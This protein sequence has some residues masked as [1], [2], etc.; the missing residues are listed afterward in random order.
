MK[1]NLEQNF[2]DLQNQFDVEEPTVG[3]LNR[4]EAKLARASEEKQSSKFNSKNWKWF[5]VA[6]AVIVSIGLWFVKPSMS[7]QGMQLAEVS[8]EMKETQSFFVTTINKELSSIKKLRTSE[9]TKIIDN[10]LQR[11]AQLEL[12]YKQLT[13]DLEDT[14]DDKRIIYAMIA[15]FQQRIDVLQLLLEQLDEIKILKSKVNQA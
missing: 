7:E 6:S 12:D 8:A 4:F 11:I 1:D 2:K 14:A 10:A 5:S 9:N 15:N 13:L 3:H